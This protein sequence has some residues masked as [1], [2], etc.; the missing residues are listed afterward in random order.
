MMRG[1]VF[2]EA[3][4]GE[5]VSRRGPEE[6]EEEE[7]MMMRPPFKPSASTTASVSSSSLARPS[8]IGL[9]RP[10]AI[11]VVRP[12]AVPPEAA[13]AFYEEGHAEGVSG[14][15][16]HHAALVSHEW[17]RKWTHQ[18]ET[19]HG[20]R[21]SVAWDH[22][23]PSFEYDRMMGA[24]NPS[25]EEKDYESDAIVAVAGPRR[26]LEEDDDEVQEENN[27]LRPSKR[28]RS[29]FPAIDGTEEAAGL[30]PPPPPPPP[31]LAGLVRPV[32][33]RIARPSAIRP[34][35]P[36]GPRMPPHASNSSRV[37]QDMLDEI[38]LIQYS[39]SSSQTEEG[40]AGPN[41]HHHRNHHHDHNGH[42]RP[43]LSPLTVSS[44]SSNGGGSSTKSSPS[45]HRGGGP[46]VHLIGPDNFLDSDSLKSLPRPSPVRS[47][48]LAVQSARDGVL[49]ALVGHG[50]TTSIATNPTFHACLDV[51]Q[52]HHRQ[53]QLQHQG[54]P[55]PEEGTWLSLTAP[56]FFGQIGTN[57]SGDP[58]YTLG[59]M[60]FDMFSPTSLVCSLQGTFNT[61]E[62]V[63]EASRSAMLRQVPQA[64][65]DE[66]ESNTSVLR[67]YK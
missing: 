31:A 62:R 58:L 57:D 4:E 7:A 35:V 1:P 32:A 61:V 49:Q 14:Q 39:A 24:K 19:G 55:V 20:F 37:P 27:D 33:L 30:P 8:L 67:T 11:K 65:R 6:E 25:P 54:R 17:H 50:G 45:S 66:V 12:V 29:T 46:V 40:P 10:I 18:E 36:F 52:Q 13:F 43:H 34:T 38:L 63:S 42:H 26:I 16:L 3:T 60:A 28:W 56:N 44:T 2:I 64:L 59:R 5:V 53:Q 21:E 47:V 15:D 51:L 9:V 23:P 22:V 48:R 41:H